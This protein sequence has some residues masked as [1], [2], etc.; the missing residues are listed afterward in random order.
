MDLLDETYYVTLAV[1]Q[2][3]GRKERKT[4]GVKK[5]TLCVYVFVYV[6]VF[7]CVFVYV[8]VCSCLCVC[9]CVCVYV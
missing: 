3:A 6:F 2:P 7:V 4:Y 1:R 9:L 5:V 8:F